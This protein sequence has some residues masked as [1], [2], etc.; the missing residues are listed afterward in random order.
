[1]GEL[2]AFKSARGGVR[3]RSAPAGHGTVVVFT[4][5]WHERLKD[6]ERLEPKSCEIK[7]TRRGPERRP[8][9]NNGKATG[10]SKK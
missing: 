10:G 4:G 5:I 2:I 6:W 7:R 3:L 1:M 8:R 9:K